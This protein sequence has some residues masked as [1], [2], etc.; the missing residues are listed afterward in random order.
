MSWGWTS[1]SWWDQP[2]WFFSRNLV[3][4][5]NYLFQKKNGRSNVPCVLCVL[6]QCYFSSHSSEFLPEVSSFLSCLSPPLLSLLWSWDF[7]ST[8]WWWHWEEHLKS[9]GENWQTDITLLR[10]NQTKDIQR[11]EFYS[12]SEMLFIA[13]L[14]LERPI[15]LSSPTINPCLWQF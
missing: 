1:A 3:T 10:G 15:R 13:S 6:S 8:K 9:V 2:L 12:R 4:R 7:T 14:R 5:V 11:S